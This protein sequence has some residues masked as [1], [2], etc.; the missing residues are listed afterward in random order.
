MNK[1]DY[2]DD[3]NAKLMEVRS[4]HTLLSEGATARGEGGETTEACCGPPPGPDT[5]AA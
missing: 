2:D 4:Q 5:S 3:D 1:R